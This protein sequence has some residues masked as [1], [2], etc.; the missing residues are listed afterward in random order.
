MK[1]ELTKFCHSLKFSINFKQMLNSKPSNISVGIDVPRKILNQAIECINFAVEE[2]KK[3]QYSQALFYYNDAVAKC[4]SIGSNRKRPD[5]KDLYENLISKTTARI[6]QLEQAGYRPEQPFV[7][8]PAPHQ[9]QKHVQSQPHFAPKPTNVQNNPPNLYPQVN[10]GSSQNS[11]NNHSDNRHQSHK[12][13]RN[14]QAPKS[15]PVQRPNNNTNNSNSNDLDTSA[16]SNGILAERPN[17]KFS[18]VAGLEGA[19]QALNEAVIMPI[20]VPHLFDQATQ[21]WRGILLYGPPG[22]GKSFLAKAVAGEADDYTFLTVSTAD[23]TS[24]WVGESE[25][26]I[27]KLFETARENRPAVIFLDEID[28]LVSERGE[29]ESESGRRIKTEFLVQMDGVGVDNQGVLVVAA[30]NLPWALDQAMRRR[31]EKRIYVPLPDKPA[32][33][34]L[35]KNKLKDGLHCISE[36]AIERIVNLTEGYSGADLGILVRDAMMQPIREVQSARYF[37]RGKAYGKDGK[38]HDGLWIPCKHDDPDAVKAKWSDLNP[39][40]IGKLPANGK[41]FAASFNNLKP[42]VSKKDIL[43]YEEWT[44]M[45][46]EEGV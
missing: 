8:E 26:L 45:Y 25:K 14:S 5:L 40:E 34:A 41:H 21:P 2:E 1:C 44:K 10:S 12:P 28:S 16:I 32:R 17:I 22:T 11:T 3:Q 6:S 38:Q 46:G 7:E 15:V 33:K 31:F 35:L 37:K 19:K 13:K 4:Q 20:R 23:L 42:S 39:D 29:G 24:K 43:K 30:T 27:K 36:K 18:D 9:N